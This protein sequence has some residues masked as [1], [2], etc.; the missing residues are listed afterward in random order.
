[1][2]LTRCVGLHH[3][4]LT[5]PAQSEHCHRNHQVLLFC[6]HK[7]S[8]FITT[9]QSCFFSFFFFSFFF[10]LRV[11]A[12]CQHWCPKHKIRW[13]TKC[14]WEDCAGCSECLSK[15]FCPCVTFSCSKHHRAHCYLDSPEGFRGNAHT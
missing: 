4:Q 6:S 13:R 10:F 12:E 9:V 8:P 14:T 3:F 5:S 1:M 2:V 7:S 15:H 11:V